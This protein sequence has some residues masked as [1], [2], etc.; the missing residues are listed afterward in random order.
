MIPALWLACSG[1][2]PGPRPPK[3]PRRV[4]RA[5]APRGDMGR[6]LRRPDGGTIKAG[7]P[8]AWEADAG[9]TLEIPVSSLIGNESSVSWLHPIVLRSTGRITW[10]AKVAT[11]REDVG[12]F[13]A[14]VL[15]RPAWWDAFPDPS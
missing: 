15:E 4:G 5:G 2:K 3:P 1:S 6:R 9:R 14:W 11:V 13:P 10:T 8:G 7:G 12:S